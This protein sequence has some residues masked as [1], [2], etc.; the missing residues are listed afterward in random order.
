MGLG[1]GLCG[2]G[3]IC[4]YILEVELRL[5]AEGLETFGKGCLQRQIYSQSGPGTLA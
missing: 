3:N 5:L 2:D 1:K 4:S